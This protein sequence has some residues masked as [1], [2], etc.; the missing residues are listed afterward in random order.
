MPRAGTTSRGCS[1]PPPPRRP[2]A[3]PRARSSPSRS[4]AASSSPARRRTRRS[5]APSPAPGNRAS[6][7]P[8]R[9]SSSSAGADD[10]PLRSQHPARALADL[11]HDLAGDR[12]D[13]LVGHRLVA[14]LQ[15]NG[16]GDRLLAGLDPLALVDVEHRHVRDQLAVDA[17]RCAHDIRR[18][19]RAV[20]HEGEVA[21]DRLER[22]ELEH[23]L[24]PRRLRLRLR[25]LFQ[26][27]LEGD[28]RAFGVERIERA[29]VELAEYPSTFCGPIWMVPERPGWNQAGAPGTTCNACAGAPAAASTASASALASNASTSAAGADQLRPAPAALASARRTPPAAVS[30]SCGWSPRKICPTSNSA[31]SANPR[32]AFFCAA[33][34]SPGSRLGRMSDRSDAIGLASASSAL[35]PPNSSACG[36]AMNDQ[37][38]AS[39]MPRAASARLALRARSWMGVSTGL[40]GAS[41]R[42]NGVAGMRST[43]RMRT[44]SSTKS[45]LSSTSPRHDGTVTLRFVPSPATTKP[46]APSTR[47][48][49]G[50]A[51]SSPAS[52]GTSRSGNSIIRAGA[53]GE[54][55]TVICE[56]SPP[57]SSST[58]AVASSRPRSEEHTSELQSL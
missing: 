11:G 25:N 2:A 9:C 41:P 7:P 29:R 45:A 18:L 44:T 36:L 20:D 24:R 16:D 23:R 42:S 15:G 17:L 31:A 55:A 6:A 28:Q 50:S 32:S 56:G 40:R 4:A 26:H 12:L 39:T 14:R 43:P 37:D 3:S 22:R 58:I 10:R 35:P 1:A 51:T 48:T 46:S 8:R 38:T 57:H 19:D 49:S 33:A 52:R 21:C 13:L 47:L 34:T 5:G 30:W 27:H 54:P 53:S